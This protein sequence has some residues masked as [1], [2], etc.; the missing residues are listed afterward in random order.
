MPPEGAERPDHAHHAHGLFA[1]QEGDGR[2][3]HR[4]VRRPSAAIG[5]ALVLVLGFAGVEALVGWLSGSLALVSDAVHMLTDGVALALAWIAQR[6]AR[7]QP[8]V[9]HSFGF[10]RAEPLAAFVN[11][12]FYLALLAAIAVEAVDRLMTP[13]AIDAAMAFPVAVVGLA[14]N[15]V[16]LRMLHGERDQINARAALLHVIGDFAGSLI[17]IIAIGTAWATG[18]TRIDP[19]LSLLLCA[20][21]L[22][23]T[24][25]VMRDSVRT[26]MNAAPLSVDVEAVGRALQAIDGVSSVH[27]LHVWELGAGTGA[28][29]AHIR[30]DRIELWP[31]VLAQARECLRGRFGIEHV[32]LQPEPADSGGVCGADCGVP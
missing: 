29:A 17:A 10:E 30:L 4:R 24:L 21:M 15:A 32:T 23:T 2:Y 13:R 28:L 22:A 3:G 1:H 11:A 8:S 5:W 25:R 20:L 19:L 16:M 7:R 31:Q 6:V 18:W 27:D 26:L 9:T 14:I 12:L